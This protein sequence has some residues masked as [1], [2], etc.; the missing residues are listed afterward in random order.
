MDLSETNPNLQRLIRD[1]SERSPLGLVGADDNL[2]KEDDISDQAL[3]NV[4]KVNTSFRSKGLR[5][6]LPTPLS[7]HS[8][9]SNSSNSLRAVSD[10][11]EI[12]VLK[13]QRKTSVVETSGGRLSRPSRSIHSLPEDVQSLFPVLVDQ[14]QL[15]V[16]FN[17]AYPSRDELK[18]IFR[19]GFITRKMT[20]PTFSTAIG[21]QVTCHKQIFTSRLQANTFFS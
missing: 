12:L 21:L 6:R 8:Q 16:L 20:P 9:A 13:S 11:P 5:G 10:E 17:N 15:H 1:R 4:A 14:V 19:S 7:A 2:E 18:N 3:Q